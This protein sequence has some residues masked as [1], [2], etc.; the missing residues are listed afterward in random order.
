MILLLQEGADCNLLLLGDCGRP[1]TISL[2]HVFDSLQGLHDT[3]T[4]RGR[5]FPSALIIA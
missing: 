5:D 2:Q 4:P 3:P 1:T